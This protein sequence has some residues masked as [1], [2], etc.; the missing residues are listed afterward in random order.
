MPIE[1]P[2]PGSIPGQ[3]PSV[4]PQPA[5]P[6]L[7]L[8]TPAIPSAPPM[9]SVKLRRTDDPVALR[10][11]VYESVL[12]AAAS[13][14]PVAGPTHTLAMKDVHYAA[15]DPDYDRSHEKKAIL[16]RGSLT[17]RLRGTWQLLDNAT[18]QVV[19][20]KKATIANVPAILHD[21]T[22]LHK[23]TRYAMGYQQR[24]RPGMYVR[25]KNSGEKEV[26]VNTR[27]RSGASHR[28]VL[29]PESG[30][31]YVSIG[32]AKIP[33]LPLLE[34]L[35]AKRED[36]EAAWG[37]ELLKKNIE[38]VDAKSITKLYDRFVPKR[39]KADGDAGDGAAMREKIRM[40][41]DDMLVDSEVV[42]QTLGRA[43]DKVDADMILRATKET[44][45]LARGE[46]EPD[47]RDH[48]AFA[49]FHSAP[50]IF[51]ERFK[52]DYG[53]LRRE[54]LYKVARR[55]NVDNLPASVLD[56]QIDAAIFR[57]G[58]AQ[59]VEE[60]NPME[61]LNATTKVTRYG[62]G[63][64]PDTT[65][66]PD[67][68]RNVGVG[69]FGFVDLVVTPESLKVGVD[70]YLTRNTFI[71]ED[72]KL[73]SK[74]LNR[75][76]QEQFVNP[77]QILKS[78]LSV[79]K[80][81]IP[82]RDLVVHKGKMKLMRPEEAEFR[83]GSGEDLFGH[84]AGVTPMKSAQFG[85]RSSMAARM[86]GQAMALENPEAPLV[87]TGVPGSDDDSYEA[88][89]GE[90]MGAV[91]ASQPGR[92]LQVTP[93]F[94]EVKYQGGETKKIS[95]DN[96]RPGARKSVF[97]QDPLVQPGQDFQPGQLLAKSNYTDAEGVQA[98]GLNLRTA[99]MSLE[100]NWEDGIVLSESAAKRMRIQQAYK[101]NL[102][103]GDGDEVNKRSFLTTFGTKYAPEQLKVIGDDGVIK[104]G[105]V[106]RTG[107]PL[108]LGVR[109]KNAT[110]SRVHQ[111]GKSNWGDASV[112]WDHNHDGV[113][114][115]VIKTNKGAQVVVRT[116]KGLEDGDKLC[117][118]E[119]T[120]VLTDKG[121]K[122][123]AD[124]ALDDVL[125][126]LHL[127]R[128]TPSYDRPTAIYQYATGGTMY[129]LSSAS[130]DLFITENHRVYVRDN[131]TR[132]YSLIE[133]KN[134]G[135]K[136]VSLIACVVHESN[137]WHVAK[138]AEGEPFSVERVVDYVKPV[139]CVEVPT[140]IIC[141]R[142]NGKTCWSGNSG[143]QGNKGVITVWP[144]A[145]MPHD[146]DG[147]PIE[148][149]ISP[150][151]VPSRG[152]S[153]FPIEL[154]L[155][156]V[157]KLRGKPYR[158]QDF[159]DE[160]LWEF[161][162]KE[163]KAHGVEE[164]ED[165]IDPR[166]GRKIPGILT[167]QLFTM[168]LSH[169]AESK[170][171]A[172]G[173][174]KYTSEG[175]PARGAADGA[176]CFV[177]SQ[178]I[179]TMYGPMRIS[180]IVE[181][182]LRVP[183]LTY[184]E[185]TGEWCYRTV[186][187]WFTRKADVSEILNIK[188]TGPIAK[189]DSQ[190]TSRPNVAEQSLWV[191]KN[192]ELYL[193][194]GSKIR[195][196][197]VKPGDR[198][199]TYG[200]ALTDDQYSIIY[201]SMLGDNHASEKCIA[202]CHGEAQRNWI[203]WKAHQLST[204]SMSM[205]TQKRRAGKSSVVKNKS[206]RYS[207]VSVDLS[208]PV[209]AKAI[210]KVCY[211]ADRVKRITDEWLARIDERAIA[212]WFIDDG[213]LSRKNRVIKQPGG[214]RLIDTMACDAYFCVPG[215][216]PA[217]AIKLAN[218]INSIVGGEHFVIKSGQGYEN[219]GI[220]SSVIGARKLV[221]LIA[222]YIPWTA[223]PKSKQYLRQTVQDLQE[224]GVVVRPVEINT[225]MTL[226]DC[227][228]NSVTPYVDDKGLPEK[229]VYD[230]TVD[231][232]HKYVAGP[233]LVSNSKRQSGQELF[234]HLSHGAYDFNREGSLL[235]GRR[236]DDYWAAFM[237]G[238]QRGEPQVPEQY[239]GMLDRMRAAGINPVRRGSK[240]QLMAMT[241]ADVD[242]L[243]GDRVVTVADTVNLHKDLEP[244]KN[245]LFDRRLFGE[246]D[247][248]AAIRLP[249]AMPNPVFEEPIRRMLNLTEKD[250]RNILGGRQELPGYGSGP[251]AFSKRLK[252][253]NLDEE[254]NKARVEIAGTRKV[255]RDNAIRRLTYF[256]GLKRA[257]TQPSDLM[258]SK[259]PVLPTRFRPIAQLQGKG[260]VMI[261]DANF[262]YKELMH[263]GEA[264][265]GLQGKVDDLHDE[266]LAIYD[267][268]KALIGLADPTTQE[269]QQR[270]VKGLL[271]TVLGKSSPKTG[272]M[273][274]RLLSGNVDTI[275]RGTVMVDS[276]LDMDSVGLP[277]DMAFKIYEPYLVR[278]L[279]QRGIPRV[280]ALE[281]IKDKSKEA[282]DALVMEMKRRPVTISRAP[283]L[284]KYGTLGMWPHL[285]RG[286]SIRTNPV[287]T[288]PMGMDF[289]GDS[290]NI[291]VPHSP[292][293]VREV[294]E[295]M[296]PSKMLISP[297]DFKS[298]MFIP[299]QD[300][301]LGTYQA[302]VSPSKPKTT[303]YFESLDAAKAAFRRGEISVD[304]P[305]SIQKK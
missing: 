127:G 31:F 68:S 134:L 100:D 111:Q 168:A 220:V 233:V 267:A 162:V 262:L 53:R 212:V 303:R 198:L 49:T 292:R 190:S 153:S 225:A 27:Q 299:A 43:S 207:S 218:K 165:L 222:K 36:I 75:N 5:A 282:T 158:I 145:E 163:A 183:V 124:I 9:P 61:I 129:R 192:H 81:S 209:L 161:A 201:G 298:P 98:L 33:L 264:L 97:H 237:A 76:G 63:G 204:I 284:H 173:L 245:G 278:N 86:G 109:K 113:V 247:K 16:E 195:A 91:R 13:M 142:R 74:V 141:V 156:K 6:Q 259:V 302:S 199:A 151:A 175:L 52:N 271:K 80:S 286:D 18:G 196:G 224:N 149:A 300:H 51:A 83:I 150:Q 118:D 242:K 41:F 182:K 219:V 32:H 119:E 59:T 205:R 71:G 89:N 29:E 62:E 270:K 178:E 137:G 114:T 221:A 121:W 171:S 23:G 42:E 297:A 228:V 206:K 290:V 197:D 258:I 261:N 64:L 148:M 296:M 34:T 202:M 154:L 240:T 107:D 60:V 174:G 17:R 147:N 185:E 181:K 293:A 54:L 253:M 180:H 140:S 135:G 104:P 19:S 144:D 159:G 246:G 45:R 244:V 55:G 40:A 295:R 241:D 47:D 94:I 186:T 272:M 38:K 30:S 289:D 131:Q 160:N 268:H 200:V 167:G 216:E 12:N 152:N 24:L 110:K 301:L 275:G 254:I 187:D 217:C 125:A 65:A 210:R 285:V 266:R 276:K 92:V 22:F 2:N 255:A 66:T 256:K 132:E 73:Y 236:N 11:S 123:V 260:G 281:F 79:G 294:V 179:K 93:D 176:Q 126:C 46:R 103:A 130:I 7:K 243:A 1:L 193:P 87:Q 99:L 304:T 239:T 227:L 35:G 128:S 112:I 133:V 20:E 4:S 25:N 85:Q 170:Q 14:E 10:E 50:D 291:S 274:R 184:C 39:M 48:L 122:P 77:G 105:T 257:G 169:I 96:N 84:A 231:K 188:V 139:Y 26:H 56:K 108:I 21:G 230:I 189:S 234:A 157:A 44:L 95:L 172:R 269:L 106:V 248:F 305:I 214:P 67:E 88:R 213:H 70:G 117:Y 232:T 251:E 166:T 177:G 203:T 69:Q 155:G 3:L 265:A 283:I 146:K 101:H 116:S 250:Y 143:R 280:Q 288:Q 28:Y 191:T 82:D 273:Q 263:A 115:D 229:N 194:D 249:E 58:L 37:P 287:A 102:E 277:K 72:N 226:R 235:R 211:G 215:W 252:A 120:E 208:D 136:D 279:V 164:T 238:Q 223:I 15:D 57:S 138:V 78:S 8:Q 90:R